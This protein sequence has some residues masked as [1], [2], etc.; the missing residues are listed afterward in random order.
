[1]RPRL[2]DQMHVCPPA[3]Y[4]GLV[5]TRFRQRQRDWFPARALISLL[6]SV[7]ESQIRGRLILPRRHQVA[8]IVHEVV[9][10]AAQDMMVVFG[11]HIFE[12]NC[13]SPPPGIP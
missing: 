6:L 4:R 13:L 12:P 5:S 2:R 1:M 10:L 11:A 8:I 7:E 3:R 9:L